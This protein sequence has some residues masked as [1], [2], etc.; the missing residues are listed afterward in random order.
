M[1]TDYTQVSKT[2]KKL[3]KEH[4]E[5]FASGEALSKAVGEGTRG[6]FKR[7]PENIFKLSS[8][9]VS[10]IIRRLGLG[11]SRC[12]WKEAYGDLHHIKGRKIPD[13]NNHKNVTYLCPNCHRLFHEGKIGEKDVVTLD[14]QVGNRWKE[15]Y[16]G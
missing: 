2:M 1:P 8:R 14:N 4:P 15:A 12:G 16:Y 7:N 13:A 3:R 11:C 6:K 9:T 10:K 5:R